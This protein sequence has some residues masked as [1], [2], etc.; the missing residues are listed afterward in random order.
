MPVAKTVVSWNT[1]LAALVRAGEHG[2]ALDLFREMQR[3]GVRP[4]GATFVAVLG[5]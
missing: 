1:M 4:D 2:E 3:A 5:A